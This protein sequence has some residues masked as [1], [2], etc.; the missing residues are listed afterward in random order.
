MKRLFKRRI[1]RILAFVLVFFLAVAATLF[2]LYKK[3][4]Y[5][6]FYFDLP[7]EVKKESVRLTAYHI[8]DF[9]IP[10]KKAE[11]NPKQ[12]QSEKIYHA[13][14]LGA[15]WLVKMQEE[16]GRFNYWYNPDLYSFSPASDD[17]FL[18]QAGTC[19]SM[20]NA[21]EM[22]GDTVYRNSY[23]KSLEYLLQFKEDLDSSHSYFLFWGKAKLGGI[24]LPMLAMLKHRSLTGDLSY[25][26]EL[27]KLA[28]MIVLQQDTYGTGQFKSTYIYF[29]RFDYEK[30]SGW[31]S[32]I[33]PG[34]ALYAL[35]EMY[36][37]F[38][39]ELYKERFDWA[40][41]FYDHKKYWGKSAFMPWTISALANMAIITK[42]EKY[43]NFAFKITK[44]MV[45]WQNMNPKNNNLGSWNPLPMVSSAT[46]MEALGDLIEMTKYL[47]LEEK[48]EKY[49]YHAKIGYHWLMKL[50]YNED[51][52]GRLRNPEYALGG[53]PG[54]HFKHEIRIDNTQHSITA[55]CK[56]LKNI[57]EV[58]PKIK[59]VK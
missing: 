5:V 32:Q 9:V 13:V 6:K 40:M 45:K 21:W 11:L 37:Q 35:S 23:K 56:G 18:R 19:Y 1:T 8:R 55:L 12:Q 43:S 3:N 46:C 7:K 15:N 53:F 49:S 14:T 59:S 42:D 34:E 33:Y 58:E 29:G 31:E 50:Q 2:I 41:E 38:G 57:Y 26:E 39:D 51:D 54:A 52:V 25:D 30:E 22:T 16:S 44:K 47:G 48:T 4:E 10:Y 27:K 28:N 20:V 17:N 36:R 24:A